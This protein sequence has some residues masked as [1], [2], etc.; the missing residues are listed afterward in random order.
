MQYFWYTA[1]ILIYSVILFAI[2]LTKFISSVFSNKFKIMDLSN[3]SFLLFCVVCFLLAFSI[4]Q[5]D[6]L[7]K[8]TQPLTEE[9]QK[10]LTLS[11]ISSV[12]CFVLATLYFIEFM[13][14]EVQIAGRTFNLFPSKIQPVTR[15]FAQAS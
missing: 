15:E 10:N 7:L 1:L 2:S 3:I 4:I 12:L 5:V 13:K 11:I 8:K 14:K 9:E 6:T